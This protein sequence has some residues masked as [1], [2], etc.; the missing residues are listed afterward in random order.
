[1]KFLKFLARQNPA[2]VRSAHLCGLF[3]LYCDYDP[4]ALRLISA[5]LLAVPMESSFVSAGPI[6]L[7][8]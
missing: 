1:M 2:Y 3:S 4:F 8:A 5:S 6:Y 7:I